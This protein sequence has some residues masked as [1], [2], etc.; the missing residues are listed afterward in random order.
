MS[1]RYTLRKL[2]EADCTTANM[3]DC[4]LAIATDAGKIFFRFGSAIKDITS[5]AAD[6]AVA[7]AEQ[8]K[9]YYNKVKYMVDNFDTH[10]EEVV[11]RCQVFADSAAA[12]ATEAAN[13]LVAVQNIKALID[14]A[15]NS[16]SVMV[17]TVAN[18]LASAKAWA[19][20]TDSPDSV[21]DTDSPTGKTQSSRTWAL[22]A[23][24]SAVSAST[25]ESNAKSSE[26]SSASSASAAS[27]SASAAATS[28]TSADTDATNAHADATATKALFDNTT[29]H[30]IVVTYEDN[31]TETINILGV[32]S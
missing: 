12:K 32:N 27:T 28:A 19:I 16:M 29:K 14:T 22:A 3:K 9:D 24:A 6:Y 10:T 31:T 1:L 25:S 11:D 21:A 18:Y 15:L 26:T 20:S 17:E 8:A 13:T 7:A 2:L 5:G 23:K 4:E 30:T